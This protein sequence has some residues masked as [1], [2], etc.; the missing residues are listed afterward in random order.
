[1]S[2]DIETSSPSPE[3]PSSSASDI[4][5]IHVYP[6]DIPRWN[7]DL[8]LRSSDNVNFHVAKIF[9]DIAS[10]LFRDMFS[11]LPVSTPAEIEGERP[12]IRVT[13]HSKTLRVLLMYCY[14]PSI[15]TTFGRFDQLEEL[16]ELFEA[17]HKYQM[18]GVL[19]SAG[20]ALVKQQ[21]FLEQ[22]PLHV[23]IIACRYKLDREAVIAARYT[24]TIPVSER[25]YDPDM[26]FISAG[27]LHRLNDFHFN[28]GR[29]AQG[30]VC[31]T[32]YNWIDRDDYSWFQPQ[33]STCRREAGGKEIS[34]SR[35]RLQYA[36]AFWTNYMDQIG[37]ALAESPC[38]AV[39]M[40][41]DLLDNAVAE[42]TAC[43]NCV[44]SSRH[45]VADELEVFRRLLAREVV[46][47]LSLVRGIF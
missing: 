46:R 30:V 3:M 8:I 21:Q 39:V 7:L 29:A 11:H 38:V 9:L 1:M 13:E 2:S 41:E 35:M 36:S 5:D 47:V 17:A 22:Q 16:K 25:T 10:P 24:L 32:T 34:I 26:E 28:C 37:R 18:S 33:C 42:A 6:P 15:A 23:Y 43:M 4:D 12:V 19:R 40:R 20:C 31:T 44:G 14:P 27:A 45:K